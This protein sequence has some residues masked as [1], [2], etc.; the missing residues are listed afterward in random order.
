MTT[1]EGMDVLEELMREVRATLELRKHK[2][3]NPYVVD[4]IAILLP[5]PAGLERQHVVAQIERMRRAKKLPIPKTLDAVVQSAFQGHASQYAAYRG[6]T[7]ADDLFHAPRGKG[8][9]I[10]AVHRERAIAWL[11]ARTSQPAKAGA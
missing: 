1:T 6:S 4:L 8:A 3:D 5:H 7:D 10:W 11:H 9:G 2:R